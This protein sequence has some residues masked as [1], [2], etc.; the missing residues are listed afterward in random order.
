MNLQIHVIQYP[1]PRLPK[2]GLR[3]GT[4]RHLPRGVKKGDYEALGY[5]DVWLPMVAPSRELLATIKDKKT[6]TPA[7]LR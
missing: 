5:F 6:V 1:S 4:V 2:H 7:F 3:L